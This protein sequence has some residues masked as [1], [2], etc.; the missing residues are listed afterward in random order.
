MLVGQA[1]SKLE[2]VRPLGPNDPAPDQALSLT[3]NAATASLDVESTPV[4]VLPLPR[5][6]NGVTDVVV[7]D[8]ASTSLDVVPNA[9]NTTIT[10]DRTDDPSGG[11]LAAV[12]ACTAAASDCSLRG[13]LQFANL[14]ANDNTTISLPAGTYVLATNGTS[15]GGC[16]G[17]A[18]GDLG[19]NRSMS[20]V[21]AGAAT[22][23]IR[24][25][26]TGPALDGDRV[27][28]MNEPFTLNLIYNFS[29][30]TFVGGRDGTAAGTGTALGGGG[31]IGGEKGNV[32]TLTNVVFANNQVTVLGSGNIG[33]GGIQ[34]T[35]GDMN[36]TNSTFGGSA[37]PGAYTDRTSTNTG[38]LQ[39]GS[40]G[41]VM[42]TPSAPQHT[43]STGILTVTG[44]TFT[45]NTAGSVGSG[46]GGADIL[47]FAF[48]A[49]G[50][51]GSGSATIG[52][53]TFSNN[54]ANPGNGGGILV[55]S[56]ATTVATTSLTNNSAGNRGGGIFVGGASLLLNGTT[57]SITFTGNTATNGGSSVSTSSAV[58]VD[59][60]NTTIGGDIE[61]NTLGSWTNNAGSA[62]APTNVWLPV[63]PST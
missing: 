59:G 8:A 32:L 48:A 53:S 18:V 22:T 46:G 31:I 29:G 5:K 49:P 10:V 55:E 62:L 38:N 56:L 60:T 15:A 13:A 11:S 44:S 7:L 37:L 16:D 2:I 63:A 26:G 3:N 28:C 40:G 45:R 21:G 30:V 14:A 54:A 47:N 27:M 41:G 19:A 24:Q 12:S 39:A 20:I 6:L 36:V 9:P 61:I 43:A 51:F 58:S 17:N 23:I 52:T 35:G 4:A 34:W 50:G 42:F 1:Q 33:G 57:P 25:T